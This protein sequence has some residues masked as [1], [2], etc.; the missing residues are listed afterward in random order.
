[1]KLFVL[2]DNLPEV[3]D[4][5]TFYQNYERSSQFQVDFYAAE[6]DPVVKVTKD[7]SEKTLTSDQYDLMFSQQTD[8]DYD[9][10]TKNIWE[11]GTLTADDGWYTLEECQ[12]A[13]TLETMRSVRVVI[14]DPDL[15]P[16][17]ASIT[18]SYNAKVH[19]DSHVDYSAIA[20]NSFGYLYQVNTSLL[21]S[22][23]ENVGVKIAG[24]PYLEKKLQNSK[25][26]AYNAKNNETFAFLIYKNNNLNLDGSNVSSVM[27]QLKEKKIAF[28]QTTR[29]VAEGEN[30]SGSL[31]LDNLKQYTYDEEN[32][33]WIEGDDWTWEKNKTYTIMELSPDVDSEFSFYSLD[34]I[35]TNSKMFQYTNASSPKYVDINRRNNWALNVLKQDWSSEESL[36]GAIFGLYSPNKEDGMSEEEVVS[37][38]VDKEKATLERDDQTWYLTDIETSDKEGKINWKSLLE[39]S[40]YLLEL[41][42]PENYVIVDTE[43]LKVTRAGYSNQTV[44]VKNKRTYKL[45]YTGGMG[46]T[47]YYV[48]GTALMLSG[49][50]LLIVR[51]RRQE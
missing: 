2:V 11:G 32:N 18:I 14:A 25:G 4:H 34:G 17:G 3:N 23:P 38:G 7:G 28:T 46:T 24:V 8:L 45:P 40:Y 36:S 48:L 50:T 51:K 49:L 47:I 29:T 5:T 33:R 35:T 30:T 39:D 21:Q 9:D 15:M 12:A 31:P 43:P 22:A 16:G 41:E 19:K 42:A 44:L 6:L 10:D 27:E 13:G 37:E 20:W 26:K 1:M